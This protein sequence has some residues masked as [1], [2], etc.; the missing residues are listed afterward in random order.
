[1]VLR[2]KNFNILG[3]HEKP[4]EGGLPKK[5]AWAVCRFNGWL[6]K[7]EGEGIDTP[8][9]IMV[10]KTNRSDFPKCFRVQLFPTNIAEATP[11]ILIFVEYQKNK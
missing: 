2:M 10:K 11:D 7:K 5:G 9:H 1:M 8:M 3:V 6:G 4:I